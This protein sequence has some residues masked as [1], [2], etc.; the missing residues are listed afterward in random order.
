M[1]YDW[2]C[3]AFTNESLKCDI[4]SLFGSIEVHCTQNLVVWTSVD[5][6]LKKEREL[7]TYEVTGHKIK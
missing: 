3:V 7:G 4:G 6:G 1:I 5:L 2:N